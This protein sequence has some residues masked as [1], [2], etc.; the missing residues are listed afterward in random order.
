M[1]RAARI[2][3]VVAACLA[4]VMAVV[5]HPPKLPGNP[6][7]K[8]L[9]VLA[10][11]ALGGL[12]AFGFRASLGVL[13]LGLAAFGGLIELIQSI[14]ALNRDSEILDLAADMAA[15][16]AALVATRWAARALERRP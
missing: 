4:F 13:F 15:A 8:I 16:L 2:A 14:P 10:F 5:P 11:A 7:D 6:S 12:A 9:H 3:F 1:H